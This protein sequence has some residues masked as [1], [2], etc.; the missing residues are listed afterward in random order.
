MRAVELFIGVG[1]AILSLG[2]LTGFIGV[3]APILAVGLLM[4]SLIL[5]YRNL[6]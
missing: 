3:S 5:L 2:S 6:P 4:A 1:G